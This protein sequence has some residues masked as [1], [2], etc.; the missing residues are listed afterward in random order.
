MTPTSPKISLTKPKSPLRVAM[1]A[2]D[3]HAV[4]AAFAGDAV[5]HSPLTEQFVFRGRDQIGPL[6]QVIFDAFEDFRYTDELYDERAGFLVARARIGGRDIEIVDHMLF[7]PDG[8]IVDFTVFF[9]PFPTAAAALRVIGA[10]LGRLKSPALAATISA[11]SYPLAT[12]A[13]LGD[14]VSVSLLRPTS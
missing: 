6:L 8:G 4:A 2:R 7:G 13:R 9:R 5:F 11:L 14:S 10:A 12:M 1:E 3:I